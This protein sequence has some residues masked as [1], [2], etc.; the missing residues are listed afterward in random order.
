MISCNITLFIY[1]EKEKE[2]ELYIFQNHVLFQLLEDDYSI[3][4]VSNITA[5]LES[6][7]NKIIGQPA[8]HIICFIIKL[9]KHLSL[10]FNGM[11]NSP[12]LLLIVK[13]S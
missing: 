11:S 5:R 13:F 6:G 12:F 3:Y 10:W 1:K 4:Y 9:I 8:T 7:R 2:K